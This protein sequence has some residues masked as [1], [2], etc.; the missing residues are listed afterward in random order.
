MGQR[1]NLH[2]WRQKGRRN[3]FQ[4][5]RLLKSDL[6]RPKKATRHEKQRFETSPGR[7]D[8]RSI[9]MV[10]WV[11]Y[12]CCRSV[13]QRFTRT[14]KNTVQYKKCLCAWRHPWYGRKTPAR[15]TMIHWGLQSASL[16]EPY[17]STCLRRITKTGLR[18][19]D[20]GLWA[21]ES[22][23]GRLISVQFFFLFSARNIYL[24]LVY[25]SCPTH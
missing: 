11:F 14:F 22:D 21:A 6:Y 13:K 16:C 10:T 23:L 25:G 8:S 1:W 20:V 15:C 17:P 12:Q 2:A 18:R 7:C 24:V 19:E 4:K 5:S 3:P 9:Q